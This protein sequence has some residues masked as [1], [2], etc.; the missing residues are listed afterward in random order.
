L[1]VA[2]SGSA[3]AERDPVVSAIAT[4][5]QPLTTETVTKLLPDVGIANARYGRAVAIDGNTTVIGELGTVRVYELQGSVVSSPLSLVPANVVPN[6]GG[7]GC[8]V[9]IDGDTI[10][11]GASDE[12]T[13]DTAGA[14]YVFVRASSGWVDQATLS[15]PGLSAG[16]TFGYALAV[17]G[18]TIVVGAPMASNSSPQQ[19]GSVYVFVREAGTWSLQESLKP[20]GSDPKDRFGYAVDTQGDQLI[21]GAPTSEG[22]LLGLPMGRAFF[23]ARSGSTWDL[24]DSFDIPL[25][26]AEDQWFGASVSLD[27]PLA[28]VGGPRPVTSGLG[29]PTV[30]LFER[31]GNDWADRGEVLPQGVND[32]SRYGQSVSLEGS[33]LAVGAPEDPELGT[34]AGAVYVFEPDG[35]GWTMLDKLLAENGQAHDT[36]GRSLAL[37]GH[38]LAVGVPGDDTQGDAAGAVWLYAVRDEVGAPCTQA[39]GCLSGYCVDGVC[40]DGPCGAGATNDCEACSVAAGAEA[41]GTCTALTE[42]PCSDGDPCTES[43]S[44]DLGTCIRVAAASDGFPCPGGTCQSGVCIDVDGGTVEP[45]GGSGTGGSGTGGSGTGGSGTD[46]GG[47]GGAS[48]TGGMTPDAGNGPSAN[49]ADPDS[50]FYGCGLGGRPRGVGLW[51]LFAVL[52]GL[53][54][55]GRR[56]TRWSACGSRTRRASGSRAGSSRSL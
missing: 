14:A 23:Y 42:T 32:S 12:A 37:A 36:F 43:A 20:G 21:V 40:C 31:N 10:V 52:V 53:G 9:A 7:Y 22:K 4:L 5:R 47:T 18:D 33:L 44:C 28:V 30:R 2:L 6:V 16:A 26:F 17:S 54:A 56:T 34:R 41:D 19:N 45:D 46:G 39:D 8:A 11:V 1:T 48:G 49:G 27:D 29:S 38:R 55:K 24:V 15:L 50:S 25:S 51:G 35:A 13:P 3:C